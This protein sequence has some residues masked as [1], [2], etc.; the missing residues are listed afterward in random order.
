MTILQRREFITLLGGVAAVWPLAAR[1]QQGERV[2]RIGVLAGSTED[3]PATR[4]NLAAL[5]EGLAKLGWIEG[6]N[7]RIDPRFTGSDP[8]RMRAY[9]VELV[10]LATEVI[11]ATSAPATRAAQEQTKTIPIVFTA[12]NDPVTNGLLQN[13]ARPEGNTTGFTSQ[14]DSLISK[15]L[16]LLK[17]AAPHIT[18]VALVFNPRTVNAG[19]FRP[20]E[21]AAPLLGVQALKTPV[22]D[23]LELV[24]AIDA[25]AAEPN[26][27]LLAV[28]VLPEDS[29]QML[30]RVAAQ[31][32]LPGVQGSRRYVA[33]G[34]L[35]SYGTDFPDIYRRAATYVHRLLR[36]AKVS[37]LPVQFPTRFE[38]VV[39]LKTA[40]RIGM[41]IPESLVLRADEVIE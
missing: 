32:R 28:P 38:L 29:Y 26:G 35:M 11:I 7:L 36:G 1:A 18:R 19:Y 40:R 12:G 9:A 17:E 22:S 13:I 20:I 4:A 31:H 21:A 27:G 14:I 33:A 15:W 30:L 24:R 6:R 8:D 5:R 10:S 39:N 41:T 34:G 23:P 37:D 16:E 25:F 3:D 2:R